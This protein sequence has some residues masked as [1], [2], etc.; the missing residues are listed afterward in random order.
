MVRGILVTL[1][2]SYKL[3]NLQ[4]LSFQLTFTSSIFSLVDYVSEHLYDEKLSRMI[5]IW[6]KNRLVNDDRYN[7]VI[8]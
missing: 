5:D 8:L 7:N 6:M 3:I 2:A 4:V 1:Q